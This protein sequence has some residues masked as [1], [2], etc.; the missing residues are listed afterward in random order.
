MYASNSSLKQNCNYAVLKIDNAYLSYS[1]KALGGQTIE[2]GLVEKTLLNRT[3]EGM[4]EEEACED[5]P[6]LLATLSTP[7]PPPGS[8]SGPM[9]ETTLSPPV[10]RDADGITP[11]T[12]VQSN[13]PPR[14]SPLMF[15][16]P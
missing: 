16:E 9:P 1:K 7:Q 5:T 6:S 3:S 11:P 2:D 13:Y 10:V 12:N 4:P 8:A 14:L 15:A